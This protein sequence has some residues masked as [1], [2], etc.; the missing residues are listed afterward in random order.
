MGFEIR[1]IMAIVSAVIFTSCV[2]YELEMENLLSEDEISLCIK[3]SAAVEITKER[4]QI[5]SQ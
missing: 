1:V 3:G 2:K 5:F 4:M